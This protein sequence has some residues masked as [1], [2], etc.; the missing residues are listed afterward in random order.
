MAAESWRAL[1][2]PLPEASHRYHR[3]VL[4]SDAGKVR[5]P[6]SYWLKEL[7]RSGANPES[8]LGPPS[9]SQPKG[10]A[11]KRP[12]PLLYIL[13]LARASILGDSKNP[14]LIM[15]KSVQTPPCLPLQTVGASAPGLHT[16]APAR[17]SVSACLVQG[18][19]LIL[20]WPVSS[21]VAL[22]VN[23]A[24][25]KPPQ[26]HFL[27]A[28]TPWH[29]G[30]SSKASN[31]RVA[32]SADDSIWPVEG[33]KN[34]CSLHRNKLYMWKA[35]EAGSSSFGKNSTPVWSRTAATACLVYIK[36]STGYY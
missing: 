10:W 31:W 27:L 30:I 6:S 36:Y 20:W 9:T 34:D 12:T 13:G 1:V 26:G 32:G 3:F 19:K 18:V 29:T 8:L 22:L 11:A 16:P 33:K 17:A 21:H 24:V 35:L 25:V 15:L 14:I 23:W 7:I 5:A 4:L 28:C 2:F